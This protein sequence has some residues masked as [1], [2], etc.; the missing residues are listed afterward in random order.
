MAWKEE[1]RDNDRPFGLTRLTGCHPVE[2]NGGEREPLSVSEDD[3]SLNSSTER[4]R[5]G[6]TVEADFELDAE[7][8][9]EPVELP[10]SLE[11]SSGGGCGGPIV[12]TE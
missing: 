6:V 2:E 4:S 12:V 8:E 5:E 10:E 3:P 9:V 1:A 11:R 7:L